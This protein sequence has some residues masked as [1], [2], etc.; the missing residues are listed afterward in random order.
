MVKNIKDAS[1]GNKTVLVRV[2]FN[3]PLADGV[4]QDVS[5]IEA[6]LPT[7]RDL[8]GR[9]AKIILISHLGRPKGSFK[10]E[11]SLKPIQTV[12]QHLVQK[13]TVHFCPSLEEKDIRASLDLLNSGDILLLENIRFDAREEANDPSFAKMLASFGDIFVNDA[14]SASH[15]AHASV[16]GLTHYMPAYGG[17]QLLHEIKSLESYLSSPE[18]PFWAIVGGAK[19]STKLPLLEKLIDV[20]DGIFVGGA[21]AN[22]LLKSQGYNVGKSLVED[23]LIPECERL[24]KTV[25]A[26]KRTLLWPSDVVVAETPES[27]TFRTTPISDLGTRDM[28]LDVGEKTLSTLESHLKGVKT[29]VWNGPLGLVEIAPYDQGTQKMGRIL[30]QLSAIK[31]AGGGDT[32]SILKKLNLMETFNYVSLAGGAFLEWLEGRELPGIKALQK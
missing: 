29:I 11:F 10:K 21:M 16:E 28:I 17:H 6:S 26:K 12:L 20:A 27:G 7:I 14:F 3:G 9:D 18:A 31:V 4:V 32:V 2:E 23:D 24:L 15:R 19:I 22:T 25:Q 8:Q 5:R 13:G 30:S 1:V